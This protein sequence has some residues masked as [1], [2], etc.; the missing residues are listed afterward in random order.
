MDSNDTY[1]VPE[2]SDMNDHEQLFADRAHRTFDDYDGS[3][4]DAESYRSS[5]SGD[6]YG[7]S[8]AGL[9]TWVDAYLPICG[10]D[11]TDNAP[12]SWQQLQD[13]TTVRDVLE[14]HLDNGSG[15]RNVCLYAPEV[16]IGRNGTEITPRYVGDTRHGHRTCAILSERPDEGRVTVRR[17]DGTIV[18]ILSSTGKDLVANS[19]GTFKSAARV[20]AA[21]KRGQA[22]RTEKACT[23][24]VVAAT[25]AGRPVRVPI[26]DDGE[27]VGWEEVPA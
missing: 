23:A 3:G 4:D 6:V 8:L 12:D 18:K 27:V 22:R 24:E 5:T 7:D 16:Y 26:M 2:Y 20:A 11:I 14:V 25:I 10:T 1:F 19:D 9:S 21:R 17:A 15:L 13:A